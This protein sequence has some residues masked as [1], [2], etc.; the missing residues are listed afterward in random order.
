MND[1]EKA[2]ATLEEALDL[3]DSLN[4]KIKEL[5]ERIASMCHHE[6]SYSKDIDY[7]G[8]YYDKAA[9]VRFTYCTV[10]GAETAPSKTV[11]IGGYG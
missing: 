2:Q 8:S 9:T 10:C 6:E 7:P 4:G 1:F 5:K 3:R 11:Y